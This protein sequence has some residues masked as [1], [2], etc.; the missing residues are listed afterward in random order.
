MKHARLRFANLTTVNAHPPPQLHISSPSNPCA[1]LPNHTLPH[2]HWPSASSYTTLRL[3]S[4]QFHTYVAPALTP[5]TPPARPAPMSSPRVHDRA[6]ASNVRLAPSLARDGR[7]H[8]AS[9]ARSQIS[10]AVA[11]QRRA[12]RSRP[13]P[14]PY[15]SAVYIPHPR[16]ALG[17]LTV[18]RAVVRARACAR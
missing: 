11:A 3:L 1:T 8:S 17:A 16:F 5:S 10:A 6:R 14:S 2:S 7:P 15:P 12:H 9:P 4:P 18:V 13:R